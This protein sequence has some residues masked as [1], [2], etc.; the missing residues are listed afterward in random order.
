[1]KYSKDFSFWLML[2]INGYLILLFLKTPSSVNL[3]IVL[4]WFQSFFMGFFTFLTMLSYKNNSS[5]EAFFGSK[6]KQAIF[7]LLHYSFFHFG[8]L[9]FLI[10]TSMINSNIINQY[11]VNSIWLLLASQTIDFLQARFLNNNA[12]INLQQSFFLPYLRV[13]PLV[14]LI[15]CLAYLPT[16]F[17]LTFILV[18]ILID[19][20]MYF[21]YQRLIN[22]QP[23]QAH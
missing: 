20:V 5:A 4:Y 23:D 8:L 7:F 10:A 14:V 16:S 18:K 6:T 17:G 15:L 9:I 22:N 11:L 13:I 1:M 3:I 21:L 12:F 19:I 2:A